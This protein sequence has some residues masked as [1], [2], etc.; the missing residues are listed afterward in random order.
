[1]NVT[2]FKS[3]AAMSRELL[4]A[5]SSFELRGP[6]AAALISVQGSSVDVLSRSVDWSSVLKGKPLVDNRT[7]NIQDLLPAAR[8]IMQDIVR[9]F[10]ERVKTAGSDLGLVK[11]KGPSM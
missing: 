8:T 11:P 6:K 5:C 4:D 7:D 10:G 1:M 9:D 3:K 2:F